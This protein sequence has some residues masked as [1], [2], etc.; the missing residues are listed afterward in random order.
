M[1]KGTS[2]RVTNEHFSYSRNESD[3]QVSIIR[4]GKKLIYHKRLMYFELYD[5]QMDPWETH[6]L[7]EDWPVFAPH[8]VSRLRELDRN[9]Q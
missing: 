1:M 4:D 2:Y 6:D 7:S 3:P 8:L 9:Y 5:L